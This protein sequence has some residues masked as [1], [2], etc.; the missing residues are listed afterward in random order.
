[1]NICAEGKNM[2]KVRLITIKNL[3]WRLRLDFLIK[4]YGFFFLS[5]CFYSSWEKRASNLFRRRKMN[6]VKTWSRFN[7]LIKSRYFWAISRKRRPE[8]NQRLPNWEV[9]RSKLPKNWFIMHSKL[10]DTIDQ[11]RTRYW[12]TQSPTLQFTNIKY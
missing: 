5:L 10:G 12:H 1:M 4:M 2:K 11:D 7:K 9:K 6:V 8:G 3:I